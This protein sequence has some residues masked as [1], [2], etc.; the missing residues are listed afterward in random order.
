MI[1]HYA[2]QQRIDALRAHIRRPGKRGDHQALVRLV[3]LRQEQE[4]HRVS[5]FKTAAFDLMLNELYPADTAFPSYPN[6]FFSLLKK[7]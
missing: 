2:L 5:S 3:Q 1:N 7:V 6:P 4:R